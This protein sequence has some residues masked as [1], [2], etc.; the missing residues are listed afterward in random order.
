[1]TD[2]AEIVKILKEV[3]VLSSRVAYAREILRLRRL[4]EAAL[5]KYEMYEIE[6]SESSYRTQAEMEGL[7]AVLDRYREAWPKAFPRPEE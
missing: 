7:R 3:G 4:T 2:D 5:K 6:V 1:M